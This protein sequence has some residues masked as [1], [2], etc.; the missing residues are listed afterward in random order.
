M[1]RSIQCCDSYLYH[2]VAKLL[3]KSGHIS[4]H[5]S[6]MIVLSNFVGGYQS[7]PSVLIPDYCNHC[8]CAED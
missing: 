4:F 2:H 3:P 6:V 7:A 5:T 1:G 8:A